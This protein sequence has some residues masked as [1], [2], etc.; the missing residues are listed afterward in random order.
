MGKRQRTFGA[1]AKS[2]ARTPKY[3]HNTRR[4]SESVASESLVNISIPSSSE[5]I[6]KKLARQTRVVAAPL[7]D[8]RPDGTWF[9][10]IILRVCVRLSWRR[11]RTFHMSPLCKWYLQLHALLFPFSVIPPKTRK[12]LQH[13]MQ[14]IPLPPMLSWMCDVCQCNHD[15]TCINR[16][17]LPSAALRMNLRYY[18]FT[19]VLHTQFRWNGLRWNLAWTFAMA[20]GT[21]Y[22]VGACTGK[23]C[24]WCKMPNFISSSQSYATKFFLYTIYMLLNKE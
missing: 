16:S 9:R 8:I 22:V 15:L 14:C 5:W 23:G 21:I 6:N 12:N 17:C 2:E 1:Y 7:H 18:I 19:C 3:G 13:D 24:R 10:K 20:N 11:W 4:S